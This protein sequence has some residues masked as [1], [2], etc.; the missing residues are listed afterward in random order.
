MAEQKVRAYPDFGDP[1]PVHENR[2]HEHFRVPA[3]QLTGE[4]DDGRAL[5]TGLLERIQF[6]R[7]RHQQRRR[8][9]WPDHARRMGVE[10]HHHCRRAVLVADPADTVENLA[11]AAMQAVE[12]AQRQHRPHPVPRPWIVGKMN[13][14]H[15][16]TENR[17]S[18]N[19]P[20][21]TA[22][23]E[24]RRD[25]LSRLAAAPAVNGGGY[26]ISKT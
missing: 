1:Q 25:R 12:I 10:G 5:E 7:L 18:V 11:V 17:E 6:L 16:H 22:A 19:T 24:D 21:S 15:R 2:P 9:V 20:P 14:V 3:R 13:D 23:G 8:L 4:A 26:V